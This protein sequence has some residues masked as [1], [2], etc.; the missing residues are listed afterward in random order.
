M[1][2]D[3]LERCSFLGKNYVVQKDRK[4]ETKVALKCLHNSQDI[5]AEL[6]SNIIASESERGWVVRCFGQEKILRQSTSGLHG[7]SCGLGNIHNS[8]LI[9]CDFHCGNLLCN[10]F[11]GQNIYITDLGLCQSANVKSSQGLRPKSNYKIPQ[12]IIDIIIKCW[13]ADLTKRP[14][15]DALF[16]LFDNLYSFY[17]RKV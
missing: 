15:A 1:V 12:L 14:K 5:S 9:H 7:I 11:Y 4:E 16:K 10:T 17:I 2:S 3:N 6:V 8:G 13:D